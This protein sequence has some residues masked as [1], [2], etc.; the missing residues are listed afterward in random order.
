MNEH[1]YV[2]NLPWR[3]DGFSLIE[4]MIA[5]VIMSFGLIAVTNLFR[6]L[7]RLQLDREPHDGRR[8]DGGR[9]HGTS[10]GDR[11]LRPQPGWGAG[12]GHDERGG[13]PRLHRQSGGTGAPR[14]QR[15]CGHPR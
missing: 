14:D 12:H 13:S 11:L 7:G 6:H 10:E 1:P 8:S 4:A 15:L 2:S 9:G 3:E 5:M